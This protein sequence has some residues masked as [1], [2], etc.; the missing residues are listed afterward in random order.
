MCAIDKITFVTVAACPSEFTLARS[1][2]VYV[3][4]LI[5]VAVGLRKNAFA[6]PNSVYEITYIAITICP[7]E[8]AFPSTFIGYKI[9]LI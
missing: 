8:Y 6:C 7:C 9:A 5:A 4:T 3:V 1:F 2:T